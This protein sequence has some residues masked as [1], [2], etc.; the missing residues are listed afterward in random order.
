[1]IE[2]F[3]SLTIKDGEVVTKSV[4]ESFDGKEKTE[5]ESK[6]KIT[7][8]PSK[9]P[10]HIDLTSGTNTLPGIYAVKETDQGLELTIA[11]GVPARPKAKPERPTDF[12]GETDG[13][14]VFKLIRKKA[15]K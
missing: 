3:K 5:R 6:A 4:L 7:L 1:V 11:Y 8:D 14:R 15:E 2:T 9:T 13:V 12:K 10:G